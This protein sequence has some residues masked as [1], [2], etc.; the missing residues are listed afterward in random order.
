VLREGEEIGRHELLFRRQGDK[1][2]VDVRTRVAVKVLFV[3]AYRFEHDGQEF[4]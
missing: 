1:L 4:W 3:T 2:A